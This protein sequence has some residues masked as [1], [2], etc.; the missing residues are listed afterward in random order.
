MRGPISRREQSFE[1]PPIDREVT[2][3]EG[4]TVKELSEKLGIKGNL[5]VKRLFDKKISATINQT[6]DVK[7]AEELARFR[8]LY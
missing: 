1:P 5:V 4:I 8:R 6:L 2:I 7:V 3:A